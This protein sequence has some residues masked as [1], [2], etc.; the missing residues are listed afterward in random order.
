LLV[1]YMR[2]SQKDTTDTVSQKKLGAD[3][4]QKVPTLQDQR[5]R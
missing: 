2:E 5:A 1:A 3:V 4:S